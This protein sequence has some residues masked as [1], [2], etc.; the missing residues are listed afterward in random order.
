MRGPKCHFRHD[1]ERQEPL[2]AAT[3][4][5]AAPRK[6]STAALY[7]MAGHLR[8]SLPPILCQREA[9]A[10]TRAIMVEMDPPPPQRPC[11]PTAVRLF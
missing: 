3:A 5:K 6:Y 11:S 8:T 2:P 7:Q 4:P 10:Y 1:L 9:I